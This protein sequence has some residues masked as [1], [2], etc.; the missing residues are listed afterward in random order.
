MISK[1]QLELIINKIN[2]RCNPY[3]YDSFDMLLDKIEETSTGQATFFN[4]E[5]IEW[6]QS[7]PKIEQNILKMCQ[8]VW[9]STYKENTHSG[10]ISSILKSLDI[11]G[12]DTK[13]VP[14]PKNEGFLAS[15]KSSSISQ[16]IEEALIMLD[17]SI[18]PYR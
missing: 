6:V 16:T 4:P 15:E 18:I 2:N 8:R 1:K 11:M 10:K 7:N 13:V 14:I 17:L 12:Y 5:E 9:D 3:E